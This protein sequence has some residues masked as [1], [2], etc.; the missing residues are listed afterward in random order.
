[1]SDWKQ[2]L[3]K[4]FTKLDALLQFLEIQEEDRKKII[5]RSNFPLL[6]PLRLA[7][8]MQKSCLDDPIFKQFVPTVEENHVQSNFFTDPVQDH[9]SR[10]SSHLL[11][12]YNHRVL[13]LPTQACAMHCRYCFRQNFSYEK[14]YDYANEIAIIQND[15]TIHEVILSGGD[16]LSLNDDV[17]MHLMHRIDSI[18]HVKVIRFHSRFVIGVPE[19]ISTDLLK[20]FQS[21]KKQIVFIIHSNHEKE[22]DEEVLSS[23]KKLQNLGIPIMCQT[24]LLKGVNDEIETLKALCWKLISHGIIPYYLHQ[25]DQVQGAMHFE[26]SQEKGLSLIRELRKQL[27]GYAVFKYVKEVPLEASKTPLTD[28]MTTSGAS[29]LCQG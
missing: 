26:V 12:K 21:I 11:Q 18:S 5:Q 9:L 24:V 10:K 27:P 29:T 7:E 14:P 19:R 25:L 1:M 13:L 2:V 16:P 6:V 4:S 17:L 28:L 8:K 3:R 23:L 22:L 15:P 20:F